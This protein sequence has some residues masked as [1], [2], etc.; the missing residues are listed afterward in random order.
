MGPFHFGADAHATGAHDA[1][2][3]IHDIPRMRTVNFSVFKQIG[4]AHMFH[5]NLIS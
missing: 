4:K 2:V 3:M 5:A 1:A